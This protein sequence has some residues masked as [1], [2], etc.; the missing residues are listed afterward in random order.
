MSVCRLWY[1]FLSTHVFKRWAELLVDRDSSLQELADEEDWNAHLHVECEQVTDY[2]IYRKICCRINDLREVWRF[3]EPK[4]RRIHCDSFV[5]CLKFDGNDDLY[6]GLNNGSLQLWDLKYSTKRKEEEIHDKGVKCID[7]T[8]AFIVTG[9]YDCTAKVWRR[10]NWL[11]LHTLTLHNDSVWD[12][13][14]H[15]GIL[16]T[17]GLDGTV[18]IYQLQDN[19]SVNIKFLLQVLLTE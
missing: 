18:G 17:A 10:D 15:D 8:A 11:Q 5:L 13:R 2:L 12:L 7:V 14:V 3:R 9:S 6:C 16:G 1:D 19:G 4:L